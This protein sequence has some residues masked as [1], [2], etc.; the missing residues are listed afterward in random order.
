M[1]ASELLGLN[2]V[3]PAGQQLGRVID[4]RL[5]QDG[6]LLGGFA[7][8]RIEGFVVG[9]HRVAARLGYDRRDAQGPALVAALVAWRTRGDRYLRWDDT[10]LEGGQVVSGLAELES[11][12]LL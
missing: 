4:V 2:V 3:G 7:A 6:P 5:V 12:P 8:L 11:V 1:R 10:S 9:R